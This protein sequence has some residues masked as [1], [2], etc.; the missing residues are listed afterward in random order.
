M[1]NTASAS[2]CVLVT[3]G[4][5][6]I[7]SHVVLALLE[8]GY[9]VVVVDN[10]TTGFREALPAGVPLVVGDIGNRALLRGVIRDHRCESVMHFAASVVA[11]Q[12]V[13]EPI[14]YYE[15]NL[16]NT[17]NLV[18]ACVDECVP[19]LIFSSTAAIYGLA[20]GGIVSERSSCVPI[21]PY[22]RSK[23][24]CEWILEDVARV[25]EL[26]YMALR[27]FNVAGADPDL[28]VG[29]RTKYATHLIKVAC[30]AALGMRSKVE[31]FGSDYPTTD[32]TGVRD[33]IHVHDL[34]AAHLAALK[35]L[36]SGGE[37]LTLNV[38][39]GHGYS[40]REVIDSVERVTGV[41]ITVDMA[42]R[43]PGDPPM[44][45]ADA[46]KIRTS[47]DWIPRLQDIDVIIKHSWLWQRK[48][49]DEPSGQ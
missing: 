14:A 27:Y 10:L 41:G 45:V 37:S 9:E 19:R 28:R 22:G 44:I 13:S 42:P 47:L 33:Y 39:Y 30:E 35:H 1:T 15:N 2:K 25:S 23:L 32:G 24:A 31:I 3:G 26:R 21:S 4:A 18:R 40:V 46:A 11:P 12:S 38:G 43:R 34:S 48:L 16:L 6:Y 17:A 36:E 8:A 49:R 5:G 20:P 7:G 29:Q